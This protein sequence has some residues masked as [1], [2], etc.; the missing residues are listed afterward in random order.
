MNSYLKWVAI[1]NSLRATFNN[2]D[3]IIE[4]NYQDDFKKWLIYFENHSKQQFTAKLYTHTLEE[5]FAKVNDYACRNLN[6]DDIANKIS[7]FYIEQ[8]D[9]ISA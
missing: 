4:I 2:V 7:K 1:D 5:A 9:E 6:Y 3:A 8:N